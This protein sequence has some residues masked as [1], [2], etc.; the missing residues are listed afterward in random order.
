MEEY[1]PD[2][3]AKADDINALEALNLIHALKYLLPP[4]PHNYT[5][6]VNTDNLASKQ[7]LDTGKGKD[8]I[9]TACSRQIWFIESINSTRIVIKHKP[10]L[11][12]VLAD[13]LS[14]A[15]HSSKALL[16][17]KEMVTKQG[18]ERVRIQHTFNTL[19]DW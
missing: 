2:Y 14:R 13:A 17:A 10:G 7:T 11:T 4:D 6:L 1:T 15:P 5:I 9:L 16:K 19:L 8:K 12:L 18:L 3:A